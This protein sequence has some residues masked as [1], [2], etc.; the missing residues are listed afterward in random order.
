MDGLWVTLQISIFGILLGIALGAIIS[1][2]RMSKVNV[3]GKYLGLDFLD[4]IIN[5]FNRGVSYLYLDIVRGTPAVTQLF[6]WHFVIFNTPAV[7][8]MTVVVI[9]IGVNS[10]AYVAEIIRA[11]LM[12]IDK[13][14]A[15]A[16]RS[17]GLTSF[18][19]MV[20]IVTPQAIKNILPTLVNEFIV[21]IKETA[22]VSFAAVADLNREAIRIRGVTFHPWMP[23]IA[24]AIIYYIIIKILTIFLR[25]LE[26]KIRKSDAR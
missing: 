25:R 9:A 10:G 4:K 8:R 13:G 16:G 17:L 24:A 18:R 2:M 23:I 20:F 26:K 11:G 6:I 5:G 14:Q 22:I 15:E 21:L 7:S 19:T 12:S 1:S 3:F